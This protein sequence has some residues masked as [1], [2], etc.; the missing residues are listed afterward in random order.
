M[1][2]KN[3]LNDILSEVQRQSA[4]L[5]GDR[6]VDVILYGSYARGDYDAESDIDIMIL[7][8][9]DSSLAASFLCELRDSVYMLEIEK[10]CVISLCVTPNDNFQKYK[11]VSPFYKNVWEEG[12][13]FAG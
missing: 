12:I 2:E 8:E 7:A 1:C 5:F 11:K 6:L 13:R 3:Q 4:M 9:I 10:D